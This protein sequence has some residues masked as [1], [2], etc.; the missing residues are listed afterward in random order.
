MRPVF[1]AR[2]LAALRLPSG[3]GRRF[4]A[5]RP[6]GHIPAGARSR[7]FIG[8]AVFRRVG[9]SSAVFFIANN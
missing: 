5:A 9:R 2:G 3:G 7:R 4:L 6:V 8:G 1:Q